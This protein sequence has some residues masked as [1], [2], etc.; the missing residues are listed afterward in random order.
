MTSYNRPH[1]PPTPPRC[2]SS[3]QALAL[4]RQHAPPEVRVVDKVV[5]VPD[6]AAARRAERLEAEVGQLTRERQELQK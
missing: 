3:Y 2:P 1:T 5:E 6:P 4:A